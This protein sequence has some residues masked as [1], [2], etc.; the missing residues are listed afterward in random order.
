MTHTKVVNKRT[1][2]YDVYI[3]RGSILGNPFVIGEHGTRTEVIRLYKTYFYDQLEKNETFKQA[4]LACKGHILGCF[5][6]PQACH[7][8]IIKEYL[9]SVIS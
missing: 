7:G 5:C 9:D 3:G 1:H 4:V 8:D 2:N 6:K